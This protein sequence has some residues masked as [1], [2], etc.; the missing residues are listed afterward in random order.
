MHAVVP[1]VQGE[2]IEQR[3]GEVA[4]VVDRML[5]VAA[6]VPEEVD[7]DDAQVGDQLRQHGDAERLSPV[8]ASRPT[9]TPHTTT[10]SSRS[11]RRHAPLPLSFP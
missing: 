11:C 10:V 7:A 9:F 1:V 5:G 6:V 4:G 3:S 8:E 2:E